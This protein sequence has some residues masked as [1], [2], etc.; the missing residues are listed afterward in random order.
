MWLG[1]LGINQGCILGDSMVWS[2]PLGNQRR[3][4]G[5]LPSIIEEDN[6]VVM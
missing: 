4:G 2:N 6:D 3:L 5:D 1:E